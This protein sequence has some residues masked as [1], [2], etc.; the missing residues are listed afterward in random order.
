M[1]HKH[2]GFTLVEVAL[3]LALTGLLFMGIMVGTGNSIAQQRFF[4]ASQDYAEFLRRVYSGV[5]NPQGVGNGKG[6]LAI[7]GK[8]ISFGQ[9]YGLNGEEIPDDEQRIFVYDVIGDADASMAGSGSAEE[10]LYNI[11]ASVVLL[12]CEKNG[13]TT[14]TTRKTDCTGNGGTI[15][16]MEYAGIVEGYEPKW[17]SVIQTTGKDLYKGTILVA[18][19]PRSG[20]INTLISPAVLEINRAVM[21]GDTSA[22]EMLKNVL[23]LSRDE[24]KSNDAEA[25]VVREV[26]FC[27]NPLGFDGLDNEVRRDVRIIKNARN[28]SGIEMINIDAIDYNLWDGVINRCRVANWEDVE[29]HSGE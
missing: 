23:Y 4:D 18:R 7:Y 20:T 8:L 27:V 1:K 9:S 19:H 2:S 29:A 22:A 17:S 6:E 5:S 14:M 16:G 15:K 13:V 10:L 3:F 25:F 12:W 21:A 26:D 24:D 11:D 28:A